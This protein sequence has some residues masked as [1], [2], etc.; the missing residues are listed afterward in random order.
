MLAGMLR[1]SHL[2]PHMVEGGVDTHS[3]EELYERAS[4]HLT[5]LC[6]FLSMREN[7]SGFW[8]PTKP[9]R[10]VNTITTTTS[11]TTNQGT[12]RC[13][14][15]LR[16][17]TAAHD[18]HRHQGVVFFETHPPTLVGLKSIEHYTAGN[19]KCYTCGQKLC[20]LI[21]INHYV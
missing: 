15:G 9:P 12:L 11:K 18:G 21:E 13:T 7:L 16:R 5:A 8:L 4:N 1:H 19:S 20:E 3:L 17:M 2:F 6:S 14:Y 10:R